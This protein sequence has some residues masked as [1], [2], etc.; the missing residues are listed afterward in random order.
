MVPLEEGNFS[1][2]MEL[3]IKLR[4]EAGHVEHEMFTK[5]YGCIIYMDI[6]WKTRK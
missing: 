4:R 2:S 3:A 5:S 1:S 6:T